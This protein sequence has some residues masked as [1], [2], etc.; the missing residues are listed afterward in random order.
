[1]EFEGLTDGQKGM[2]RAAKTPE[3]M[4]A[5]ARKEGYELTDASSVKRTCPLA[6]S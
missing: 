2:A 5:L 1:M 3:E 4:L 6:R